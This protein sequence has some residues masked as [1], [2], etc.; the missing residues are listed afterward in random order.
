MCFFEVRFIVFSDSTHNEHV[1]CGR[2]SGATPNTG[3]IHPSTW[4][5]PRLPRSLSTSNSMAAVCW[6]SWNVITG[7][8][9][10]RTELKADAAALC[11]DERAEG[12]PG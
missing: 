4:P 9:L 7:D 1:L 8:P 6:A 5:R 3:T 11:P 10:P 12:S 2:T